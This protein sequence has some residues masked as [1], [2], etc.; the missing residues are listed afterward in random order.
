METDFLASGNHFVPIPKISFL[1]EAVFPSPGNNIL[2]ESLIRAS[3]NGLFVQWE[4]NSFIH[5]FFETII[6]IR[7]RR[8]FKKNLFL[9]VETIF[10]I[11]F[12]H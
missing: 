8:I 11:F 5:I 9:L 6:A 7:G 3:G 2:N 10:Y 12:R 1:L 4:R